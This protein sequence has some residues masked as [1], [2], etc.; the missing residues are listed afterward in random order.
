MTSQ[1]KDELIR[2]IKEFEDLLTSNNSLTNQFEYNI[3]EIITPLFNN[4]GYQLKFKH[5]AGDGGIDFL[6]FKTNSEEKIGIEYKHRR[7]PIGVSAI[8]E[9]IGA[10]IL[11]SFDRMILITNSK[12]SRDCYSALDKVEPVKLELL[13]LDGIKD[14]VSKI[15]VETDLTKSDY[16]NIIKIISKVFIEKIAKDPNF[17]MNIEWRELE[18]T[19]S[20]IFEGLAFKVKLTPPSKD[21]GK[22]V[23]LECAKKGELVSYIIEIKHWRSLQRVGQDSVKDFLKVVCKEK[24]EAGIFLST[25]GFTENAFEGISEL[26]RKKIKFGSSNKI[27]SLCKT[28]LKVKSGI[29]TPLNDLQEILFEETE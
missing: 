8:R 7:T 12:F 9:L 11:N 1:E 18:K 4:D 15:E 2:K 23:I 13:N 22:D 3:Y 20:E 27:V 10:A 14:W 6:A 19:I 17:L 29:W 16:E 25:Y 26:E 21:G 28:Y 24:R 5:G